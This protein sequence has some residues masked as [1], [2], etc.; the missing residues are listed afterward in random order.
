MSCSAIYGKTASRTRTR[1]TVQRATRAYFV[2]RLPTFI[3]CL[4]FQNLNFFNFIEIFK[5]VHNLFISLINHFRHYDVELYWNVFSIHAT[6]N[7]KVL[8]MQHPL[9]LL[10]LSQERIQYCSFVLLWYFKLCLSIS[11]FQKSVHGG[12]GCSEYLLVV[13][14]I[15]LTMIH[16]I[17]R[18]ALYRTYTSNL[19]RTSLIPPLLT[20]AGRPPREVLFFTI[21]AF[22]I[23][24]MCSFKV[25]VTVIASSRRNSMRLIVRPARNVPYF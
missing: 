16:G 9:P 23:L 2:R 18:H 17:I 21:S 12:T 25:F 13:V 6:Y 15:C 22:V 19:F 3:E 4:T 8:L 11:V 1:G 20:H 14:H 24:Q 5:L 10:T 7:L